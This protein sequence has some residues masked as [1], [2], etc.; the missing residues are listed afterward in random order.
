MMAVV[1]GLNDNL[2]TFLNIILFGFIPLLFSCSD[3]F[4][5][6]DYEAGSNGEPPKALAMF[7]GY[8][9]QFIADE[10]NYVKAMG[11]IHKFLILYHFLPKYTECFNDVLDIRKLL[12]SS[13][14][15][16][17]VALQALRGVPT[18][19]YLRVRID[20]VKFNQLDKNNRVIYTVQIYRVDKSGNY[21]K[22]DKLRNSFISDVE[23]ILS[24][25]YKFKMK[26]N[27]TT[28]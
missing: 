9:Q 17:C 19:T 3:Q 4:N 1:M 28:P 20:E 13:G 15:F 22:N 12:P 24:T 26:K 10:P 6:D 27:E 11:E 21:Y 7:E 23:P 18:K 16:P 25:F 5:P 2:R 14:V 8:S